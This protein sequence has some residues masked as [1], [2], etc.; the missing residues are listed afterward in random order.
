MKYPFFEYAVSNC[1]FHVNKSEAADQDQMVVDAKIGEFLG[2]RRNMNVWL[3]IKWV[4]D[5]TSSAGVTQVHIAA[6]EGLVSYIKGL[7]QTMDADA[8]DQ[9]GRTPL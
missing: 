2:H 8:P 7:L 3:R 4:E 1:S 6:R 5:Y 9:Q